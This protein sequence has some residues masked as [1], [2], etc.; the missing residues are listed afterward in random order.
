MQS[1][2]RLFVSRPIRVRFV[3][4]FVRWLRARLREESP[5][6]DRQAPA[7]RIHPGA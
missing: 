6:V 1:T 3:R 5:V 2:L 4:T 7:H